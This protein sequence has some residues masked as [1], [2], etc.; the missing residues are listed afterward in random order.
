MKSFGILILTI[1]FIFQTGY[2]QKSNRV[3]QGRLLDSLTHEALPY[4]T[5]RLETSDN[6]KPQVILTD[7]KGDFRFETA[8]NQIS[9]FDL[10]IWVIRKKP[11][12]LKMKRV[13]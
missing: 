10:I 2:A 7:D 4:A 5:V 3:I 1:L 13:L 11:L 6:A 9:R 12:R 8:S